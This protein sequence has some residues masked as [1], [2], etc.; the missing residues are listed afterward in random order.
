MNEQSAPDVAD[1]VDDLTTEW[2]TGALRWLGYDVTVRS[3][4]CT[5]IGEGQMGASYRLRY[6]LEPDG[7]GLPPTLVAKLAAPDPE[8]RAAV[9]LGYRAEVTFYREVAGTVAVKAPRCH[10]ALITDDETA[11]TLLLEDLAPAE[12]GDQVA[13][14]PPAQIQAAAENLAA[15]HGPRWDDPGLVEAPWATPTTEAAAAFVGELVAGAIPEL[16]ARV[17]DRVDATE[18]ATLEA[19][20]AAIP[21]FLTRWQSHRTV[22]HGDY[23]L[24]NLLFAPDGSSVTAVDWQTLSVGMPM[25]DLAYLVA[26]GLRTDAR[27]ATEGSMLAAYR[28]ALTRFGVDYDEAEAFDDYRAG[29]LQ[30]PMITVLGA[31]F[32]A[33]TERGDEMF[34]AMTRRG[35]AAIRDHETVALVCGAG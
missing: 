28:R 22:L 2:L 31:A 6:E 4:E 10:L 34:A 5:P 32:S 20:A 11:F 26:T 23:R 17:G 8:S 1:T 24:D 33:R 14:A 18:R 12:P 13:G 27:R 25:R 15:L 19:S 29:L 16:L 3:L 35:C 7:V 21:A 9:T 30:C